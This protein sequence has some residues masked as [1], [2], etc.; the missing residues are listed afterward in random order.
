[1]LNNAFF[2]G[3]LRREIDGVV[4]PV[5]TSRSS[6]DNSNQRN[7]NLQITKRCRLARPRLDTYINV[8]RNIAIN[9]Q[10]VKDEHGKEPETNGD[11]LEI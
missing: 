8:W 7:I 5:F 10:L 2:L 11:N 3:D 9:T 4:Q 1:M 6:K